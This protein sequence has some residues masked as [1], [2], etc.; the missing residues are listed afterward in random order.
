MKKTICQTESYST[1]AIRIL[2]VEA[3]RNIMY[4]SPS[5]EN[6]GA[7]VDDFGEPIEE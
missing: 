5:G 6:P 7:I 2:A 4:Q 1:P 3:R